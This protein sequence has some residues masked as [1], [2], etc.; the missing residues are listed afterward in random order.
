MSNKEEGNRRGKW[1]VYDEAAFLYPEREWEGE[2][3]VEGEKW[4][5][6]F[7]QVKYLQIVFA[8]SRLCSSLLK[9]WK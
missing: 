3:L 4:V 8:L 6:R 7:W 2:G 1:L 5:L 9:Y